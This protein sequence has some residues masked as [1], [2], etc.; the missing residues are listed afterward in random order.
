MATNQDNTITR[1]EIVRE[2][3]EFCDQMKAAPTDFADMDELNELRS[4]LVDGDSATGRSEGWYLIR[5]SHFEE[6][7][8]GYAED[9]GSVSGWPYDHIDWTRAADALKQDYKQ[10]DY[11]G[12]TY[13]VRA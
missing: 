3:A 7:A 4:L 13:W 5:D 12:E 8:R 2:I 1:D 9:M 10:L 6:W 11:D